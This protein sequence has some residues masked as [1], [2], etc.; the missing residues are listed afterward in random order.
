[1]SWEAN[2]K[3]KIINYLVIIAMAVV[4]N[5]PIY[6]DLQQSVKAAQGVISTV[7]ET[8]DGIQTE[9]TSIQTRITNLQDEVSSA[10]NDGLAQ[11]DSTL[12]QIK[13]L[14][15]ET[16]ALNDKIEAF[17]SNVTDKVEKKAEEKVKQIIPGIPGF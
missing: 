2:M 4:A 11:A 8:I 14:R 1:M 16:G 13:S 6:R 12:N 3:K 15:L 17:Q 5:Y 9:V 7:N 10:I